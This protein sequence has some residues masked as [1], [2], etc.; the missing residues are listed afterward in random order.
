MPDILYVSSIVRTATL[1]FWL[2]LLLTVIG[3]RAMAAGMFVL[4]G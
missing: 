3:D 2:L 4:P 1:Y